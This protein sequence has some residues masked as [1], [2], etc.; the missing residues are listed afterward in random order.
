MST[1][2]EGG[3]TPELAR[4]AL[5][6]DFAPAVRARYLELSNKAQNGALSK[7][8]LV[9]LDHFLKCNDL[10]TILHSKARESLRRNPGP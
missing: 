10:L 1:S 2:D 8:E 7:E 9:E 3:I 6:L 5:A 4:Q